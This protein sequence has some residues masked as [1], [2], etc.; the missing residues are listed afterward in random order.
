MEEVM[1]KVSS[2]LRKKDLRSS[3]SC[4]Q[5]PKLSFSCLGEADK[6]MVLKKIRKKVYSGEVSC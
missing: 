2:V 1:I 4:T 5:S 3:I 6:N